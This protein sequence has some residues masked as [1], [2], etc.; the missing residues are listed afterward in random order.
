MAQVIEVAQPRFTSRSLGAW[1]FKHQDGQA[2]RCQAL[3]TVEEGEVCI[4]RELAPAE[5]EPQAQ[6]QSFQAIK[7]IAENSAQ[8]IA[9]GPVA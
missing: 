5:T 9:S 3:P 8:T 1:S 6:A 2:G 4:A 7:E